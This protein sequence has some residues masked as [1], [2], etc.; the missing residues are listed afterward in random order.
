MLAVPS[1]RAEDKPEPV[2]KVT[3]LVPLAVPQG[4]SGTI[5]L[6]GFKLKE[7][8]EV[9]VGGPAQPDE[10]G[11]KE[12][13]DAGTPSGMEKETLGESEVTIDLTLG[14]AFPAGPVPL[15]MLVGGHDTAPVELQILPLARWQEETEPNDG[16]SSAMK[17]EPGKSVC[18]LIRSQR[19]VDVFSVAGTAGQPLKLSAFA[20]DGTSLL[21]PLLTAY[22]AAGQQ[23][24]T[25]DD[26]SP[27][28]R[29]ATIKL[30]PKADGPVF[31]VLQDALDFGSEW[32]SYRVEVEK[33]G[34]STKSS[35]V[36]FARDVW[37]ILRANCVSCHRPGKLK[38]KLDLTNMAAL[39]KGG[40]HGP[41]VKQGA[42]LESPLLDEVSG[43]EPEMPPE[44]APLTEAEVAVLSRWITE[45]AVDDTPAGGLGTHRP[46][47]LPVYHSL[48]AVPALA[49]SPDGSLLAVA[50]HHEIIL[51][52]GD[53]SAIT[54]RWLGSSPRIE[55]L[56]F[57]RDGK[58]LAASG[59]APSEFGE[60]Q[61]WDVTAGTLVRSIR[62]G[63]DTLYGVSWSD[64]GTRL[65]VGGADKLVRAFD[66]A[67]GAQLMQCDNHLDWVFG[68]AFVHDGSK[69]I[70]ISRDR[71]VKLIDVAS[72]HLIDDAARPREPVLAIA[73]HPKEDMVAFTGTEGKVR[74]HRMAPRGGRLKEG[75]DKEESAVREFEHMATPLH[76]V[77]LNADGTRLACGGQSGE[78][79][80]FLTES[81]KKEATLPTTGGSVFTLAFNPANDTLAAAGSD[82]QIRFYSPDGK[83]LK[84]F[85]SV[86]ATPPDATTVSAAAVE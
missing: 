40:K 65:A 43:E 26:A 45:G 53:G 10:V 42:P 14:A 9:R 1:G 5:R 44:G 64:D 18:G 78:I 36:S 29:D 19:D 46:D 37:P 73:R 56:A 59:G 51:H 2:P 32:H 68:T 58:F 83:L 75:D 57:S 4:F 38:G 85:A 71:G 82:G 8:T 41:V 76:A 60:I 15:S 12:K 47:Q 69:L 27:A 62:A 33:A 11:I 6:R 28:A 31:I 24:A 21:D 48:P 79:R 16:F 50:G 72:G 22:D 17:L 55:S 20:G 54:G 7:A 63:S 30:T 13:K 70:S 52:R 25:A 67:S 35:G 34:A 49:F 77:A 74:L 81:G 66:A 80:V 39:L 3:A 86:P 61:I 84:A 23:L